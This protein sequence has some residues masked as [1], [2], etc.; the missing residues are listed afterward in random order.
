MGHAMGTYFLGSKHA[1]E[2]AAL[3]PIAPA[4]FLMIANRA[5]V[6]QGIEIDTI[7]LNGDPRGA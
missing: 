3:A 1:K 7:R 2:W 6:L 5:T 4:A